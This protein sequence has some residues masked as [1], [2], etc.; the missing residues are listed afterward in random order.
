MPA[1]NP[2]LAYSRLWTTSPCTHSIWLWGEQLECPTR[3]RHCACSCTTAVL[4]HC[5]MSLH[6]VMALE[7]INAPSVSL[8]ISAI[9]STNILDS[10]I[11]TMLCKWSGS[12]LF[13]DIIARVDGVLSLLHF[14]DIHWQPLFSSYGSWEGTKILRWSEVSVSISVDHCSPCMMNYV[15]YVWFIYW[16]IHGF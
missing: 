12:G 13:M 7:I 10:T 5:F 14:V 2:I 16:R 3:D 15:I 4:I 9:N 11:K 1:H 6:N 8:K